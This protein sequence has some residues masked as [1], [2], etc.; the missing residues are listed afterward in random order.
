MDIRIAA[1]IKRLLY[2]EKYTIAG[3]IKKLGELDEN[4]A[5]DPFAKVSGEQPELADLNLP[6]PSLQEF[7]VQEEVTPGGEK[8][9]LKPRERPPE[10]LSELKNLI[11]ATKAILNKHNLAL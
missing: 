6:A 4:G 3:A 7:P 9:D 1:T 8:P 2:E 11:A 10:K 5:L